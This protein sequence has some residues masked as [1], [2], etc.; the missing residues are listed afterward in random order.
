VL[1]ALFGSPLVEHVGLALLV[2]GAVG[3]L[4]DAKPVEERP[5]LLRS[6]QRGEEGQVPN[7]RRNTTAIAARPRR[8]LVGSQ[9]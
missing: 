2:P 4:H 7:E 5:I 8:S 9:P 6:V 1:L 3:E